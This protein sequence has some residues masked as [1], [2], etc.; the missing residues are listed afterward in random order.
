[1]TNSLIDYSKLV[2]DLRQNG[3][4]MHTHQLYPIL[5]VKGSILPKEGIEPRYIGNVLVWVLP[6]EEAEMKAMMLKKRFVARVLCEC[7]YC[8]KEFSAGTLDQHIKSY[9]RNWKG[10]TIISKPCK[11]IK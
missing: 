3:R 11:G 5:G 6:K 4:N 1:M 2:K 10:K 9:P 7:P 8:G